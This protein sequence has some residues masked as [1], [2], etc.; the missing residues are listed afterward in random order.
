MLQV[1]QQAIKACLS[2]V[3][4]YLMPRDKEGVV[5]EPNFPALHLLLEVVWDNRAARTGEHI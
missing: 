5:Q 4:H 2:R 1:D 3:S